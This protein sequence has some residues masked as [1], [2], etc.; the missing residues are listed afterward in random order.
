MSNHDEAT[1]NTKFSSPYKILGK[2]S[3]EQS[4]SYDTIVAFVMAKAFNFIYI[5]STRLLKN[6]KKKKRLEPLKV[7]LD[8]GRISERIV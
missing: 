5:N 2:G 6:Y 8:G 3:E 1:A 7:C 4:L